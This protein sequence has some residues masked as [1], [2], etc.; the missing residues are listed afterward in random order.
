MPIN[1]ICIIHFQPLEKYPPITNLL[2]FLS[3]KIEP[4]T[5]ISTKNPIGLTDYKNKRIQ[6]TRYPAIKENSISIIR[7]IQYFLFYTGSL[8]TLCKK[9]PDK[10]MYYE[11]LSSLPAILYYYLT[12]KKVKLLVHY[13]EYS[14]PEE[15]QTGMFLTHW[16]QRFE[17]KIYPQVNWISQTNNQRME[18]FIRDNSNINRANTR[19]MP[20]YPPSSWGKKSLP[21]KNITFPLKIVYVG[22]VSLDTMYF[23]EFFDW[24]VKQGGNVLFDIY[25]FTYNN[26]FLNYVNLLNCPYIHLKG[27]LEYSNFPAV[28]SD[29]QVGVILYKGHIPNYVYNAPNKL[30]EYLASGL[31]VW[32]SEEMEGSRRYVTKDIYPKVTMV[33]FKNI[34]TFDLQKTISRNGLM[35]KPSEYNYEPIYSE[36]I[37]FIADGK[38]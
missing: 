24:V 2:D 27:K 12:F 33:D 19:I 20:N 1:Q 22:S 21:N 14:S 35:Y 30:F 10:I 8:Y 26:D 38:R 28:L 18:L 15:Y 29:Y 9:R 31:D 32:I 37:N 13:H 16:F 36:L 11:T 4:I 34:D 5:V 7:L 3:D 17:Q 6:I 25:S 23:P